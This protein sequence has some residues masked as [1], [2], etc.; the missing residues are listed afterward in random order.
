MHDKRQT[1]GNKL[2]PGLITLKTFWAWNKNTYKLQNKIFAFKR[3]KVEN[4][5][6]KNIFAYF[7]YK[8]LSI[9]IMS[10]DKIPEL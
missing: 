9:K 3:S 8:F 10:T 5:K 4:K 2:G 6:F 7:K 1:K